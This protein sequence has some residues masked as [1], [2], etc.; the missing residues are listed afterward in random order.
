[1]PLY[2]GFYSLQADSGKG[3]VGTFCF[4]LIGFSRFPSQLFHLSSS[5]PSLDWILNHFFF[6]RNKGINLKHCRKIL[7]LHDEDDG[8]V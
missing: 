2:V 7:L 4:F 1:M 5:A 3:V 6:H 8:S